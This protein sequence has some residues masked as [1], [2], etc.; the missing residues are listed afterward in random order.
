MQNLINQ[1]EKKELNGIKKILGFS[2]AKTAVQS[3]PA[4]VLKQKIIISIS[5]LKFPKKFSEKN[6][7]P[8]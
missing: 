5:I 2:S 8:K 3:R 4:R 7:L 6:L 1:L